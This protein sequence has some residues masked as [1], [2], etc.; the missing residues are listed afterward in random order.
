M[1]E[2]FDATTEVLGVV[3]K[4]QPAYHPKLCLVVVKGADKGAV[5]PLGTG[6]FV[7]GRSAQHSEIVVSGRG[8]SRAHA[9]VSVLAEDGLLL[10]DLK[11]TNGT[12]LNGERIESAPL[13][14]GDLITL[15][16]D[17]TLVLEA[18]DQ[19]IQS[20]LQEMYRS[21]TLDS[22][23]GLLN[24]RSFLERFEEEVSATRRHGLQACL[25]IMDIDFFKAVNDTYGHPAGDAVLVEVA[26]RLTGCLRTEDV[27]AR[28]GGEEFVILAR[29]T[30]AEGAWVLL[31]RMRGCV[32]EQP[33]GVPTPEG[34]K[35]IRVTLSAGF[36]VLGK[37]SSL[38]QA[39]E[40]ADVA[41]YEAKR[42]G[43]NRVI[44]KKQ[45]ESP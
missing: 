41:L 23:T 19:S 13:G 20:L 45:P 11:S 42:S 5:F 37:E 15:G 33:F 30:P 4:P 9:R 8:L 28:F 3:P 43:R 12:F 21:A 18:S 17:V 29:Q 35:Q 31:E 38:E 7:L 36:T 24:R 1:N 40:R 10:E 2:D 25:G 32:E 39:M 22:L 44:E 14:P 27:L 16:P 6:V 26:Q 34:E